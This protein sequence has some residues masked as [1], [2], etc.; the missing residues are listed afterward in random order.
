MLEI[1]SKANINYSDFLRV[2]LGY[3]QR[4]ESGLTHRLVPA[5]ACLSLPAALKVMP[6]AQP[7]APLKMFCLVPVFLRLSGLSA[8]PEPSL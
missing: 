5:I 7:C 2:R 4:L 8:R 6:D 1:V 3:R